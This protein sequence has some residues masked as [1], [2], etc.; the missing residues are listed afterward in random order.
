MTSERAAVEATAA[1]PTARGSL[2]ARIVA[3]GLVVALLSLLVWD[4]AHQ[5]SG[6]SFVD[7]I[8]QGKRPAAPAF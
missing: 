8:A 6:S 3:A 4:L 7:E 2:A 1:P 5:T